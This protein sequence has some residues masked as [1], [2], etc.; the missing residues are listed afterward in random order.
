MNSIRR[1]IWFIPITFVLLLPL[2]TV[3]SPAFAQTESHTGSASFASDLQAPQN[4]VLP[5]FDT[6]GGTRTLQIVTV[7]I[8]YRGSTDIEVDNDDAFQGGTVRGR[9]IRSWSATG[10]GVA[11]GPVSTT[12]TT[13][14]VVLLEDDGDGAGVFDTTP[15]DGTDFGGPVAYP[16]TLDGT[17]NPA[18][19]LYIG[20]GSVTFTVTPVLMVND[21]QWIVGPPA[22]Y[23]EEI[24]NPDMTI[25]INLDYEYQ[26]QGGGGIGTTSVPV[27][28]TMY[29]GIAAALGAGVLAYLIH[30][31]LAKS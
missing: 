28:P 16:D 13:A 17:Y 24:Q 23:Q 21:V 6:M 31:K 26:Q 5:A 3:A 10:P 19:A 11:A 30:R 4:I 7:E 2:F 15:P 20:A 12:V 25:T 22:A 14:S 29:I 18:L 9:I 1:L 8:Y 27:F